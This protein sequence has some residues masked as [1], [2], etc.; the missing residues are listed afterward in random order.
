VSRRAVFLDR[1][2]VLVETAVRD[3][4][5]HAVLTLDEFRLCPGAPAQVA[6]IRA[7]GLLPI[8]V[9]NQPEVARGALSAATLDRMHERLRAETAVADVLVCPHDDAAGCACRKP[10]PGM[11]HE[12]AAR[13]G[14]D[15]AASFAIGDRWR[16]IDAGRAAG[17]YT[18]LLDRPY[19][20]CDTADARVAD[21]AA[22]V[23]AVLV[24]ASG[25]ARPALFETSH[26]LHR[27]LSR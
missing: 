17:C 5:A 13:W 9:T 3:D 23:D 27:P 15:L 1:D 21:L 18:V 20:H 12:A 24:R 2:G 19:S 16:D 4:R 25:P 8:V 14:I 7:A 26:G 10:R 22:A 11:L 6:R